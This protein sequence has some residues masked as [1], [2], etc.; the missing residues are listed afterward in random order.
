VIL[1]QSEAD[2]QRYGR[3]FHKKH[4]RI[5]ALCKEQKTDFTQCI[6]YKQAWNNVRIHIT[7]WVQRYNRDVFISCLQN[8]AVGL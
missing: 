2:G 6:L 5:L 8:S 3:N 7:E 4:I 1:D